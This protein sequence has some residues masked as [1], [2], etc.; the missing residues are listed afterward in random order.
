MVM[1][2]VYERLGR[3]NHYVC[4]ICLKGCAK[5]NADTNKLALA[6]LNLL[7]GIPPVHCKEDI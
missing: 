3:L 7:I 2:K 6:V 4:F 5:S 1:C